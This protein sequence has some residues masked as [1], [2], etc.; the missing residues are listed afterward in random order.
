MTAKTYFQR[1]HL[2]SKQMVYVAYL[3]IFIAL[4]L[5]LTEKI[6]NIE[7]RII[8]IRN[9]IVNSAERLSLTQ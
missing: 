9:G 8:L 5:M 6:K 3:L 2:F 4:F 1:D 7:H